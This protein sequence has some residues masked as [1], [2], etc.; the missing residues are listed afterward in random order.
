MR[1]LSGSITLSRGSAKIPIKTMLSSVRNEQ[2]VI[3]IC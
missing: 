2:V 3:K 1:N